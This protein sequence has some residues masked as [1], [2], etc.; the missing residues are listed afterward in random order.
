MLRFWPFRRKPDRADISASGDVP[1]RRLFGREY[2]AGIPYALPSDLGEMNRLDFQHFVLRQ[3]F[4]GNYAAPLHAPSSILDVGCGTGRWAK[5]MALIFPG[6]NVVGLIS[7]NLSPTSKDRVAHPRLIYSQKI[8]ASFPA[9]FWKGCHSRT[10]RL[11]SCINGCSSLPSLATAG[12]LS[13]MNSAVLP[14]PA[15][16]LRWSRGI[17]A[18]IRWDRRHN[19]LPMRCFPPCRSAA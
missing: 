7:K 1:R 17:M 18:T 14:V 3:A 9:I 8:I 16:G 19:T 13:S 12:S 15:A 2:T 4:K 11:I 10:L 6:A 5:E